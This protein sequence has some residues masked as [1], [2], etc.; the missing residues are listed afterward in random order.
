MGNVSAGL[1]L[2]SK[3]ELSKTHNSST[4]V[5]NMRLAV[6]RWYRYPA[7]FSAQWVKEVITGFK[8]NE[9]ITLFDPFVGCGTTVITGEECGVQSYGIEAHPFVVRMA[10]AKLLWRENTKAFRE[11]TERVL[12]FAE[13]LPESGDLKSIYPILVL[14]CYSEGS[15]REL[16]AL[17]RSWIHHDD[18]SSASEL[19]WL[20]LVGI[21][22]ASSFAGTAPWQYILPKKTK[23]RPKKPFDA[24]DTQTDIMI[25]DM[26]RFQS[27]VKGPHGRIFED[28]ARYCSSIADNSINLII[29]SPPYTNN[30]DYADATRLEMSFLG[31]IRKWSDLQRKVRK[32]LI[33]SCSQH[34]SNDDTLGMILEDKNLE[35]IITEL[36]EVCY[37]LS[38][39]KECHGGRK[40]YDL[41]VAAYFSDLAKVWISLRRVCRDG[42]KA[43][44]VVGDSAPYGVY[45]P[46]DRWLGELAVAAGFKSYYFEKTRDRNVKWKNRK[47]DVL[48]HEGRLWVNAS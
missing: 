13:N 24:F 17:R 34:M 2:N 7:G 47:H 1:S 9:P 33:R 45:V 10:K 26:E 31:E 16:D 23:K 39:V 21:L 12:R 19:T 42:A 6:H 41:M 44:F 40:R 4:F 28:D 30:Y 48:L 27:T 22:R 3:K 25:K 36:R 29:T 11:H 5:D 37:E 8:S 32:Y 18:H 46:V 38:K 15:L 43:C 14:K 20:A 35:P